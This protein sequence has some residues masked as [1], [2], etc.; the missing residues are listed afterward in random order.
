MLAPF[1]KQR[2]GGHQLLHTSAS[3]TPSGPCQASHFRKEGPFFHFMDLAGKTPLECAQKT[4]LQHLPAVS[5]YPSQPHT[6]DFHSYQ[7]S[8]A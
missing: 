1:S 4:S 7:H 5:F 2:N 8:Q 6:C 3:K